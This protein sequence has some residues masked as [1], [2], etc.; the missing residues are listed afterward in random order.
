MVD[1]AQDRHP[2]LIVLE[3][4]AEQVRL[5]RLVQMEPV[6]LVVMALHHLFRVHL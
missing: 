1:Q 4:V 2:I 5:E 3:E 6:E